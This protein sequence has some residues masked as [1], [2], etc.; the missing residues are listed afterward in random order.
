MLFAST[1]VVVVA[2]GVAD[3]SADTMDRALRS[4]LGPDA[5]VTVR[6]ALPTDDERTLGSLLDESGAS[7][8]GVVS[9]EGDSRA[10]LHFRRRGEAQ[11]VDRE[12]R[13][14]AEDAAAERGRTIGY[15]LASGVP[16]DSAPSPTPPSTPT[17]PP[18]EGASRV[19]ADERRRDVDVT[20]RF[21]L[22]LVGAVA[23][24][25]GGYGGGGGGA[26]GGRLALGR[27]L[28]IRVALG[29]R[30]GEVAPAQA[31]SRTY[32]VAGGVTW[33]TWTDAERTLGVGARLDVAALGEEVAHLSADDPAPDRRLRIVPGGDLAAEGTWRF[34]RDAAFVGALGSEVAL[35]ETDVFVKRRQV[36]SLVPVRILGELGFRVTF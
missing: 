1:V 2:A 5:T 6:R 32:L 22:D 24:A 11:W 16:A 10:R 15:A 3:D 12:L 20:R 7:L 19:E 31:S 34:A 26:V 14:E 18:K 21:A 28:G 30:A 9:V 36:G 27:S 8:V 23:S 17:P 29:A 13:F 4:V 35:G 25:V 33:Q